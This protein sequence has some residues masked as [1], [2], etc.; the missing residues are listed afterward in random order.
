MLP[1]VVSEPITDKKHVYDLVI[2]RLCSCSGKASGGTE[3]LMFCKPLSTADVQIRF[4]E[5]LNSQTIWEAFAK[6]ERTDIHL[7]CGIAFRTPPYRDID[8]EEPVEVYL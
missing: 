1:P 7:K 4:Y 6:F 5:E 8:I 3:I 2:T